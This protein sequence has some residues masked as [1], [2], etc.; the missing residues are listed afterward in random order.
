MFGLAVLLPVAASAQAAISGVVRDTSG[1]VL[2]GVTVEATSPALIE[3]VRVTVT[4][5]TG[6][7]AIEN[8]QPGTY[9]VRFTLPGFAVV[10]REG[11]VLA[12]TFNA[13]INAELRVSALEETITVTGESPVVDVVNTEQQRVMNRELLDA[14]PT[15]GRR[16]ALAVLIPSVDFRSQDVGGAGTTALTGSPTAHGARGEDSG[17]TLQGI[18]IASFGTSGATAVTHLNPMAIEEINISTGSTNAELH[19]GGV[20]T[21]YVVKSGG[22]AFSGVVFGAYAPG[23][24]QSTNLDADLIAR[25]L[26][27]PDK[28]KQLWDINPAFGGPIARDK[29][30]FY[31][32]ARYN[33][34][35]NYVAGIFPNRNLNDPNS[36]Q[37]DPDA[38]RRVVNESRQPDTQS[39]V[40]WQAD[41][42]NRIGFLHYDSSYCFCPGSASITSAEE[43]TPWDNY[44]KQRLFGGD[45]QMPVNNNL[46]LEA[47]YQR[48]DSHSD[49]I[50]SEILDRSLHVWGPNGETGTL[51]PAQDRVT[52]LNYRGENAYRWLTQSVNTVAGSMSYIIGSH[53]FKMGFNDKFGGSHFLDWNSVPVSYRIRNG[54]AGTGA[55]LPD[56]I[57]LVGYA[58]PG[59]D[60]RNSTHAGWR[61]DVDADVG[62]YVQDRWTMDRLTLN[63]G[64][65]YDYFRNSYPEQRIGPGALAPGRDITFPAQDGWPLHDLSPRL[66]AV[67]DLTG[68]GRTAIKASLN[69]YVLAMGPDAG[70]A[71]LANPARNLIMSATRT[72]NDSNGNFIPDC[73]LTAA[74]PGRNGEC[75]PLSNANFG[76][77]I[78]TLNFDADVMTGYGARQFNWEFSGGVQQE[79]AANVSLD[80]SYFRRRYGNF[81]VTADLATTPADFDRYSVTAPLHP[82]LPG[83]GGYVIEDLYDIKPEVFGRPH[84]PLVTLASEFGKQI[85]RWQGVDVVL[86]ARPGPGMFFQGGISSGQRVEDNC[87]VVTKASL[88]SV[89]ARGAIT[90]SHL[91]PSTQHCRRVEPLSTRFKGYGAYTIPAP[92][93]VQVAATYQNRSGAEVLAEYTFTNADVRESLGRGLS[94]GEQDVDVHLISPGKYGRFENQVGGEVRGERLHQVDLRISK[95]LNFGG[96]RARLNLDIYNA[97][98]SNSILRYLETFN[99]FLNP[100]EIL[101]ARFLKF[102]VQFDF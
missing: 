24:L 94:G 22:N 88:L 28:I 20:R 35:S 66:G 12:G 65:R 26:A 42:R 60:G 31:V 67:Y 17:T 40:T 58:D 6:Q 41:A 43:A 30:W 77:G 37:Y 62:I 89:S 92:V 87:D 29:L 72:W 71:R 25:G 5:G 93:D 55:P 84:D 75:G 56:R 74:T 49:D 46:L 33:V 95:L 36:W 61:A 80:V 98:N 100:A 82:D 18:S 44:P 8:L 51:V 7:Y 1:A 2:P 68:E 90:T 34:S 70:Y 59:P 38:S 53:A 86:N 9:V 19:A 27:T 102:S 21:N 96:P 32:A 48:Y 99:D 83:G 47:R 15:G 11:I 50:Q 10:R 97:L 76:T 45:W 57:S 73:D 14:L 3:K 63:L 54:I 23:G 39:R 78:S 85:D 13:R 69:R 79:L 64:V 101:T 16:D 91:T 81:Q 4:G 52:L